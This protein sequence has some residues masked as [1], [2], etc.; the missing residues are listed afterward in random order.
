VWSISG[1]TWIRHPPH[2]SPHLAFRL[3]IPRPPVLLDFGLEVQGSGLELKAEA[4]IGC[5]IFFIGYL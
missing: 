2:I 4:Y 3:A 1:W 5:V